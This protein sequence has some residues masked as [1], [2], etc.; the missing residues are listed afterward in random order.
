MNLRYRFSRKCLKELQA[1]LQRAYRTGSWREVR[2]ITALLL[3]GQ[4]NPVEEAAETVGVHP[5][6]L[7]RWL[8][9]FLT[10]GMESLKYGTSPGR[11]L[12][13]TKTQRRPLKEVILKGP[14]AAGFDTGCWNSLMVQEYIEREWGVVY[15]RRYVCALL[16]ELDLSYQKARFVSDHLDEEA[17]REW[18]EETW[19]EILRQAREQGAL[20]LFEDEASFAPWGSLGYTWALAGQQPTVPTSGKRK[21]YKVFGAIDYWSGRTF[22]RRH[23][24]RFN[25]ESY[26]AFLRQ[27]LG[28]TKGRVFLIQDRA[29]YH[30]SQ[31]LKVFFQDHA[32]RLTVDPLPSYSPDFNPIERLWKKV[33]GRVHNRYFAQFEDL[34]K[35]VNKALDYMRQ[36]PQEV[37]SLTKAYLVESDLAV[38]A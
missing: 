9:A 19:P 3:V 14:P 29:K 1:A 18:K 17:R 11:P 10:E 37:L 32:D 24:G 36:H 23:E 8:K 21:G 38:A 4:G 25:S 5:Q 28:S 27:I 7:Y 22:F 15:K 34:K 31:A 6:T 35:V 12:K 13:L 33:K 2:R 16:K 30:T 26:K 20:L